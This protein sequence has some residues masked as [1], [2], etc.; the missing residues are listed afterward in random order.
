MREYLRYDNIARYDNF[1]SHSSQRFS[2]CILS[3]AKGVGIK[4]SESKQLISSKMEHFDFFYNIKSE[5][6]NIMWTG[7]MQKPN[8][9]NLYKW[10]CSQ[11]SNDD[12]DILIYLVNDIPIGYAYIDNH[13]DYVETS[14]AVSDKYE[15][16]GYGRDIIIKTI[17]WC[18][19]LYS[20]PIHSWILDTNYTSLYIHE[21]IGG[22]IKTEITKEVIFNSILAKMTLYVKQNNIGV[23]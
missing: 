1:I 7:H 16:N 21:T 12:R 20:K 14:L 15:S 10:F 11:L 5:E 6:K 4:M 19:E 9:D 13:D 18:Q 8:K 3:E 17:Q 22:Y 2:S 23:K